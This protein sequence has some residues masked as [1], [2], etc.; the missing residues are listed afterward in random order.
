MSSVR[1][2]PAALPVAQWRNR[3]AQENL[4]SGRWTQVPAERCLPGSVPNRKMAKH[5]R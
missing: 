5:Q 4:W 3:E 1:N 2:R